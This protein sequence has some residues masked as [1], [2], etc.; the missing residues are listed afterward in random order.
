MRLAPITPARPGDVVIVTGSSSGMGEDAALYLNQLGYQVFAGVRRPDDGDRVRERASRPDAFTPLLLDVTRPNQIADAVRTVE[1]S[2]PSGRGVRAVF[3]NAGIAGFDGDV[4]CEGQPDERLEQVVAVDFLGGVRFVRAFLPMVRAERGTVVVNSA[5][6]TKVVIP[7]NGGYAASKSA[8][9][10][11]TLSLRREIARLGVRVSM[12]RPGAVATA[13][14]S[15]QRPDQVP[16]DT[17]YPEQR[18]VV[19]HFM[20]GMAK[21]RD[22][23]A[24]SPRRVSE[25]VARIIATENPRAHY[26]VGGGHRALTVIGAPPDPVQAFLLDRMLTRGHPVDA[27]PGTAAASLRS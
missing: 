7:F 1:S 5:M 17:L 22:D 8:L 14:A 4:S 26:S 24:C 2:L 9:E 16:G 10:T 13:L 27:S 11:W 12:I 23:P 19:E 21:H 18:T 6:M 3:S 25:L 20:G 15:H